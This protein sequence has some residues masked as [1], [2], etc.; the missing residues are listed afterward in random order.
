[1]IYSQ[2]VDEKRV[3]ED[4]TMDF[5]VAMFDDTGNDIADGIE[6]EYFSLTDKSNKSIR[7]Y[8]ELLQY[9]CELFALGEPMEQRDEGYGFYRGKDGYSIIAREGTKFDEIIGFNQNEFMAIFKWMCNN[10]NTMLMITEKLNNR[11]VVH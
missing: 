8:N 3:L 6:I 4:L 11:D 9:A 1:M 7:I 5:T 2:F 10:N